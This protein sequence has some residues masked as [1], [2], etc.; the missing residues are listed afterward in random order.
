MINTILVKIFGFFIGFFIT[1]II[2]NYIY[3]EN[4]KKKSFKNLLKIP[5]YYQYNYNNIEKFTSMNNNNNNKDDNN[6]Q[7]IPYKEYKFMCITTFFDVKQISNSQGRW[8]ECEYKNDDTN[9]NTNINSYFTFDKNINLNMNS[10]NNKGAY[11]A[12]INSIELRGPKCY[13]FA[14]NI[15]TSELYEFSMLLAVK[16][17]EI[18]E[19]NNIIFE[20]IGNSN[21]YKISIIHINLQLNENKNFDVIIQIGDVIY[22][23]LA[24]NIDKNIIKSGEFIV[25]GLI[26]SKKEI[27]FMLNKQVYKYENKNTFQITLGSTP[28]II[29]KNGLIDMELYNFI[30]YKSVIPSKEYL[31]YFKHIYY[32]LS[33]LHNAISSTVPSTVPSITPIVPS[34]TPIVPSITP[35]VPSNNNNNTYKKF[36]TR[37]EELEYNIQQNLNKQEPKTNLDDIKPFNLNN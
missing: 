22:T 18:T 33:G 16:I 13:N 17:K 37:L 24:N 35:I 12:D 34:I 25:I 19:K 26:Y 30:Y 8:F 20:M 32:Y 2:I 11:G 1:I 5:N 9:A 4:N 28:L 15:D 14:N 10:I 31:N 3:I 7:M 21:E 27:K 29:N 23:G 36:K 6:N